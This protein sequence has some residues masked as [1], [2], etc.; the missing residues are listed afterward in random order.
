MAGIPVEDRFLEFYISPEDEVK[1]D[2]IIQ[3]QFGSSHPRI[4][5]VSPGGG[6][7][8][9]KDAHFKRWPGPFFANL[10]KKIKTPFQIEA[11]VILGSEREKEIGEGLVRLLDLPSANLAGKVSILEAC[12]LLEK[13]V[14]FMGNDGGLAH[15][16]RAARI[17]L[18]AFYGPVD[19]QVYGPYPSSPEAVAVFKESLE[20]RPCYKEFRY[21]SDCPHRN[22]LQ[23]LTPEEVFEKIPSLMKKA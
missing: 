13:S 22:C 3:K 7:S 12:A 23:D 17:P 5:V 9:G 6:E 15:L 2:A 11:A 10:I 21:Q 8:W 14:L 16:A 20:C 18:I 19:P 1:T 4:L